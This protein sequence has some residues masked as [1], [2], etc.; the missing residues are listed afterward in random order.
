M[1]T[2]LAALLKLADRISD[3]PPTV[4][5][6]QYPATEWRVSLHA[7]P[8]H[9]ALVEGKGQTFDLA[10]L[11]CLKKLML[12]VGARAKGDLETLAEISSPMLASEKKSCEDALA[13]PNDSF[14]LETL[15]GQ[16]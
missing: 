3:D 5:V 11:E 7:K 13:A 14:L 16:K 10:V 9:P 6:Q 15:A 8:G 1:Q 12:V 4:Q 2:A